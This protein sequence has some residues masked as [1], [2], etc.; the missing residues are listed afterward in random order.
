MVCAIT[1]PKNTNSRKR[2]EIEEYFRILRNPN[3]LQSCRVWAQEHV[4][5]MAKMNNKI[6]TCAL[7]LCRVEQNPTLEMELLQRTLRRLGKK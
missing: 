7:R 2:R 4:V 5:G 6:R 1:V 3:A